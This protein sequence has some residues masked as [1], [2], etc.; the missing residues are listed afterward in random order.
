MNI[1]VAWLYKALSHMNTDVAYTMHCP[2]WT[3]TLYIQC[4]VPYEHRRCIYNALS[5]MNT[6]VAYTRHCPIWTPTLHIQ[7]HVSYEHRR[8]IYNVLSHMNTDVAYTMHCPIWTSTLHNYTRHCP[9]WTPI[10]VRCSCACLTDMLCRRA[11]TF[12]CIVTNSKTIVCRCNDI[13]F[14]HPRWW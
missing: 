5:H 11:W 1:D 4:I 7:C 8:C 12:L 10:F 14:K 9:K 13:W 2:I 3:P 6:D